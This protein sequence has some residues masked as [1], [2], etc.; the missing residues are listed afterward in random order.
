MRAPQISDRP[1]QDI[2]NLL[3]PRMNDL[4]PEKLPL[5]CGYSKTLKP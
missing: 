1:Q 4:H 5:A 2:G 3:G